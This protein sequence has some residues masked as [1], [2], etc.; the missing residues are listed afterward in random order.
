[1]VVIFNCIARTREGP[2]Y[3]TVVSAISRQYC[4]HSYFIKKKNCSF[5]YVELSSLVH[6]HH[7]HV[8]RSA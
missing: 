6:S 3:M 7:A 2:G 1:M 8:N 4:K 5:S